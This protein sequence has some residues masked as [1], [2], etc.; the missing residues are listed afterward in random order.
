MMFILCGFKKRT[1]TC[2]VEKS[3][4]V[5]T[6]SVFTLKFKC[7]SDRTPQESDKDVVVILFS[8][9][10]GLILDVGNILQLVY[11]FNHFDVDDMY[12]VY[13][14]AT[15]RKGSLCKMEPIMVLP[16]NRESETRSTMG[17]RKRIIRI[18]WVV[19]GPTSFEDE[20]LPRKLLSVKL[21]LVCVKT[22][23]G[24]DSLRLQSL[25]LSLSEA[26]EAMKLFSTGHRFPLD[27]VVLGQSLGV[28]S[29]LS[30]N[31]ILSLCLLQSAKPRPSQMMLRSIM[32][33]F[34]QKHQMHYSIEY[35]AKVDF[36]AR[37]R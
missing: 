21:D 13:L 28:L 36:K 31:L 25:E 8:F 20:E 24:Q 2:F 17:L 19:E 34:Y 22:D 18:R 7:E 1:G 23:V 32:S 12:E 9:G 26:S 10:H 3:H 11:S 6:L 37:V 33:L 5:F 35:G 16:G 15:F 27:I 14:D 30:Q 4:L 29:A